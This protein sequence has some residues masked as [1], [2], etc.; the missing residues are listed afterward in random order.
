[1]FASSRGSWSRYLWSCG[2]IAE[3]ESTEDPD[4]GEESLVALKEEEKTD[5]MLV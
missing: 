1:M 4:C 5:T 3:A 2:V